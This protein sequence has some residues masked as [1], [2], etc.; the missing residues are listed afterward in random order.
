M[1]TGV[2][3]SDIAVIVEEHLL[4]GKPVERLFAAAD[5]WPNDV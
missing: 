5:V 1:Y 4:N 3:E 2:K